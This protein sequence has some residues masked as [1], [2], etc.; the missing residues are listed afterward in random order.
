MKKQCLLWHIISKNLLDDSCELT[1]FIGS[2][3]DFENLLNASLELTMFI[4]TCAS[5][6]IEN[7]WNIF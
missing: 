7:M 2:C 4:T 3:A 1:M 6:R 5:T